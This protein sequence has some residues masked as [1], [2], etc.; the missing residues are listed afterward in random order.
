[1]LKQFC[2]RKEIEFLI[3]DNENL[4]A[5][6][7]VSEDI[8][9]DTFKRTFHAIWAVLFHVGIESIWIFY[10]GM[11]EKLHVLEFFALETLED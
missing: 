2:Q 11:L 5:R 9:L 7:A 10:F 3:I 4:C 1:L 8:V 6:T